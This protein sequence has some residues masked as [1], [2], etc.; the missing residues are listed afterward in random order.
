MRAYVFKIIEFDNYDGDSFD[1]TLDLG[2]DLIVHKKVRINGIDTPE[3]RGGTDQSKQLART[4][5]TL[6]TQWVKAGV[7]Q[8]GCWFSSEGYKGKFGRPLGDIVNPKVGSLREYLLDR[9]LGV[10]YH[11]QAKAAIANEHAAI[12]KHHIE[13]GTI[14]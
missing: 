2:F 3:M 8:G 6:A 1:L 10:P 13:I 7:E 4:A 11:G 12:I 9:R 5:K 14:K